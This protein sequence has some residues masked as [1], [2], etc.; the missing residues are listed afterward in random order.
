LVGTFWI[1]RA[2]AVSFGMFCPVC[3]CELLPQG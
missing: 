1:A 2:S 3:W